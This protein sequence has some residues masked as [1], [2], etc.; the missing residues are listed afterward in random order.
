MKTKTVPPKTVSEYIATFPPDV[1]AALR[2]VRAT[3]RKALPDAEEAIS[4]GIATFRRKGSNIIYFA[5]WK[6]HFSLY[7]STARLA[8]AFKEQLAP[9]EVSG[10]GTIRFPLSEPVPEKLIAALAKFR[11]KEAAERSKAKA[12]SAK[13]S[14]RG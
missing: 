3:I 2:T 6:K 5:G 7:P 4:Y 8:A 9:Y 1:R 11:A 14:R 10:K 12:G 13:V